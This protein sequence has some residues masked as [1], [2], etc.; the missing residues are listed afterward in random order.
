MESNKLSAIAVIAV[1]LGAIG[2]GV[3]AYSIISVQTGAIKGDEGD[4]GDDGAAGITTIVYR[5]ENEYPC[6][7]ETDINNALATIGTGNGKIIITGPITLTSH[8]DIDGGGS[9]IIQGAGLPTIDCGGD[10]TAFNIT[11]AKSCIIKDLIIEASYIVKKER[12]IILINETDD[13]PVY[14]ENLQILGN[15]E[16]NGKGI[17]VES[18]NIWIYN[19]YL[20]QF[21]TGIH[22]NGSSNHKIY[23]NNIYNCSYA[24][25]KIGDLGIWGSSR[26]ENITIEN[27]LIRN[28]IKEIYYNAIHCFGATYITIA[29]NIFRNNFWG[30]AFY[31]TNYSLIT[32]N[33]ITGSTFSTAV[34]NNSGILLSG[35]NYNTLTNN[36][37]FDYH[38]LVGGLDGYGII[39]GPIPTP[40]N[41]VQN[42]VIGNTALDNDV[43]F[44]D[45]GN[46]TFGN[47]TLNNFG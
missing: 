46:I 47:E 26:S 33:I 22:V 7:S 14:I 17:Y 35:A 1:I 15:I 2:L 12:S 24:G 18:D 9:Y 28:V 39:I 43:N 34:A 38:S 6:S 25:I 4:D 40:G 31:N 20:N 30:I 16:Q 27:N 44:G 11:N 23:D 13:N 5:T 3:G 32:G 45:Y 10:R 37:I 19:C 41:C 36:A 8:I 42:T 21:R 29:N